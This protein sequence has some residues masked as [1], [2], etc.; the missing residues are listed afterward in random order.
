MCSSDLIYPAVDPLDSTSRILSPEVVGQEHYEVARAVQQVKRKILSMK[1]ST[2]WCLTS[3]KY[4]AIVRPDRATRIRAPGGYSVF[5]G[6]G[7][8]TREGND[9]YG[10][11]RESGV[12]NKT[13]LVYGQMNEPPVKTE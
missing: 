2:S 5:T 9:L 1:S 12:L 7:E 10:E 11:M 8:R 6:V 13:A 3:R 4:S